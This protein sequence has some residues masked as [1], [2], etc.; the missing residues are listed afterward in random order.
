MSRTLL[1]RV[2]AG[3]YPTPE[4]LM[5]LFCSTL[6]RAG[7][8]AA[9]RVRV[10]DPCCGKGAAL[11]AVA[12][13]LVAQ[14]Y[15]VEPNEDRAEEAGRVL[16]S[17]LCT[18]ALHMRCSHDAFGLLW[19]NPPY[20]QGAEESRLELEFLQKTTPYLQ[21]GGV[22]C[23][24][25]PQRVVA[26]C[27]RYLGAWYD[28]LRVYR[29]PEPQFS[30]YKQVFLVGRRRLQ[31]RADAAEMERLVD[32]AQDPQLPALSWGDCPAYRVPLSTGDEP[33]L[34]ASSLDPVALCRAA[35][36]RGAWADPDVTRRLWPQDQKRVQPLAPLKHGHRTQIIAAG[37]VN[38]IVVTDG[39]GQPFL[40]KGQAYK[41]T[42]V[43]QEE[44]A[45]AGTTTTIE[46]DVIRT[47]VCL[48]DLTEGH[49]IEVSTSKGPASAPSPASS[50]AGEESLGAAPEAVGVD[51]A[52]TLPAVLQRFGSS[53][54]TRVLEDYPPLYTPGR[55]G[56]YADRMALLRRK[57]RGAQADVCRAV[58][59]CLESGRR[60]SVISGE[61]GSGK[62]FCGAAATYLA[63]KSS[64]LVLCPPHLV[65]KWQREIENTVPGARVGIA[66]VPSDL[67][68]ILAL[69]RDRWRTGPLYTIVSRERAKLRFA[70]RPAALSR[71]L[72]VRD[73]RTGASRS[74]AV[75]ACP[76][77]GA[78]L[79]D[80][81]G[82]P[83]GKADLARRALRCR[84]P[85]PTG[86]RGGAPDHQR[87]R[88]RRAPRE[89][90]R[91]GEPLWQA[92]NTR[93]RRVALADYI[94]RHLKGAYDLLVV[95]ELHEYAGDGSAQ[96]YALGALASAI[97]QTLGLTGTLFGGKSS[98]LFYLLYRMNHQ[99]RAEFGPRDA[100]RWASLY[101]V[102]ERITKEARGDGITEEGVQ[103][104]RRIYK[105][106]VRER[107]GIMPHLITEQLLENVVW[108]RLADVAA[109]LPRYDERVTRHA[110]LPEQEAAYARLQETLY[111]ALMNAL[112]TGSSRLLG[113]YLQSLL[114]FPDTCWREE[115]VTEKLKGA[116]GRVTERVIAQQNA[117][118]AGVIYPKEQALIDLVRKE[119]LAGRKVLVYVEHTLT[120][121][122]TGRLA[123]LLAGA[124]FK[125][126]VLKSSTVEPEDREEWIEQR[127][128][129]GIHCL[130]TH[131]KCV[132]TGLDLL[133]FP[134]LVYQEIQYSIYVLRQAS[135]RSWRIGQLH[136]VRVHFW[137]YAATMQM[138]A[139]SL[140]AA[141]LRAANQVDGELGEEGLCDLGEDGEDGADDGFLRDLARSLASGE[142]VDEGSLE[143]LYAAARAEA[144]A[145]DGD[146]LSE[147]D[148]AAL[149]VAVTVAVVTATA[150]GN[151]PG[152][153]TLADV[154]AA[155]EL[156]YAQGKGK[157]VSDTQ[158]SLFDLV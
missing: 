151:A 155:R 83:L 104:K 147:E 24:I 37:M 154:A 88:S 82:I 121:D 3:F 157:A 109:D 91:C 29:F 92:D 57:P 126:A 73:E 81:R 23:F 70:K 56:L 130:L 101:G 132:Q 145:A 120:R 41:E 74:E 64:V 68:R 111:A 71:T 108:L 39:D 117:L 146:L 122:V 42:V 90:R 95:D 110:M 152:T 67:H 153:V 46:R 45:E 27:A 80:D 49:F 40:M 141:K 61:M 11:R 76:R 107:P 25:V 34:E 75:L 124:G 38:D 43:R 127:V 52:W 116:D 112:R 93:A 44:D 156:F 133:A 15:G 51:P 103:S 8:Y 17:V 48:L 60:L 18:D 149:R 137:G 4:D 89:Q 63:G 14:S 123:T 148:E 128:K 16:D 30:L 85:L 6:G 143:A 12:S 144:A 7:G 33:R 97:P 65:K 113:A 118:D 22:L 69:P 138:R 99:V 100:L 86:R 13:H 158:A 66:R 72:R 2:K 9:G 5:A 129:E 20:D 31:A 62:S 21:P 50:G 1:N 59:L 28:E 98:S 131:P 55:R 102:I 47:R 139:L 35:R 53:I 119:A 54:K 94:T 79:V 142:R 32:L 140:V 150:E 114:A 115:I 58:A 84:A 105:Q 77:C 19:L 136:P 87:P 106:M 10:L 134:T 125:V 78:V 26:T 96:G 135:R 36:A